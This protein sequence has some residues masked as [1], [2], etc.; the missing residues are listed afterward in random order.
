MGMKPGRPTLFTE[1]LATGICA[2][3]ANGAT[4]KAIADM[5]G[6]P[7]RSTIAEWA[8]KRP[9]F[10]EVLSAARLEHADALA[11]E[12][13]YIADTERDPQRARN[14]I[15]A[16]KWRAGVIKPREYGQRLDLQVTHDI[17]PAAMH[18]ESLKR[19]NLMRDGAPALIPQTIDGEKILVPE[20][21]PDHEPSIFD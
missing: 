2:L 12:V 1:K 18:L 17:D 15:D 8:R 20:P 5:E 13:T 19:L 16:R 7:A 11:D 3:L 14:M 10:R 4:L 6:M 21:E 9:D